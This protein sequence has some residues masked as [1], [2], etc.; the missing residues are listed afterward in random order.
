MF[1]AKIIEGG[2]LKKII[3]AIRELVTDAN[4]DCSDTGIAM[5]AMDSSHVSLCALLMK[6]EGFSHYRCDKSMS[7]GL[8][9]PN[10]A[11]VL[12]CA[13]NDDVVTLKSEEGTDTLTMVFESPNQD[14]ISDFELKL[15][16]IDSEH[17]GIP[18]T[19]YKCSVRMPAAEFQRIIRDLSVLGDTC[20]ISCTKEG[21][22]FS[23]QGDL[24]TGKIMLK[25]SAGAEEKDA[26]VIDMQEPV[27]LNFA[28]RYLTM[29]TKATALGPFVTLSLSP[30]V[31][32][33]VEYPI[34]NMGYVR[35][36][37]APKIDEDA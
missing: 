13:G 1:E 7:L 25:H 33:V 19:D 22:R 31:P 11:K 2:L 4:L 16:D 21:I 29:F 34:E 30:D 35:Y 3:E 32:V 27:E 24:G 36:Y 28:I 15:M 20:T 17:L 9:T 37:L 5:Q 12:K 6:A 8:N 10:L 23:A 26:V 14:R 18:E